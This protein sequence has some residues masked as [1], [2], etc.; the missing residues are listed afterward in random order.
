MKILITGASGHLGARAID[1][2]SLE[3]QVHALTRTIPNLSKQNVVYYSIDLS[4]DW[5]IDLLPDDIDAIIH[6]AQSRNYREFPAR[7]YEIY[8]VNLDS[9]A[10]LLDYAIRIGAKKFILASTGG[11]Y[12][13]SKSII[14]QTSPI[15][16][17]SGLLEYYFRTKQAAELMTEPY[18][19]LIDISILRPFFIYG[20]GQPSEKL[21]ARL[22]TSI[23]DDQPI[24]LAGENGTIIN[25]V[26]VDDVVNLLLALLKTSGSHR[27]TVA[28]PDVLSIRAIAEIIGST[29]GRSPVFEQSDAASECFVADHKSMQVLI[30]SP[31]TGFNDGLSRILK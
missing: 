24:R 9:T 8:K 16:P 1:A 23:S 20:P 6:L 4:S 18:K 5:A 10:K 19:D 15:N 14:D 28:G 30:G 17:S 26:F 25:P 31:L 11:L 13:S 29:V 22:I 12:C 27:L 21:I 7:A 3:N 2:L